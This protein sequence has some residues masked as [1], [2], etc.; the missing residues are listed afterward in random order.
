M[1]FFIND[2]IAVII[3][4]GFELVPAIYP[5]CPYPVYYK[6]IQHNYKLGSDGSTFKRLDIVILHHR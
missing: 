5:N 4:D 2:K 1:I 6:K 3:N